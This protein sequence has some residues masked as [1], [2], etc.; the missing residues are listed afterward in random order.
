MKTKKIY[1]IRHGQT[2]YNKNNM[3]QGRGINSSINE[4]GQ[5]QA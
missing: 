1:I 2:D 5:E 4:F 3:V